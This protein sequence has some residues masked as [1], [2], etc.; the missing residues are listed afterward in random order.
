MRIL[1]IALA[2]IAIALAAFSLAH[3]PTYAVPA[4]ARAADEKL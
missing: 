4:H 2:L 1:A 3:Q